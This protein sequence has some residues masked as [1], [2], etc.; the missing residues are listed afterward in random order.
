MSTKMDTPVNSSASPPPPEPAQLSKLDEYRENLNH[1]LSQ[2]TTLLS[3]MRAPL[4][5]ETGNGTAL[6]PE[7]KRGFLNDT[8]S[9]LADMS[10]L[11]FNTMEKVAEM[12]IKMKTG[13]DIDDREYLME[14]MVKVS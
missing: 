10:K 6:P 5:T 11:G 13:Q 12:G 2:M 1:S 4:P 3:A 14:Y 8:K 9:L 7:S